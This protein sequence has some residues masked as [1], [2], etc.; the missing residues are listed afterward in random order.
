MN[1]EIMFPL[2]YKSFP[3]RKHIIRET[4]TLKGAYNFSHLTDKDINILALL[5]R[6]ATAVKSCLNFFNDF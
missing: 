3:M 2:T 1:V 6:L 5:T 4:K